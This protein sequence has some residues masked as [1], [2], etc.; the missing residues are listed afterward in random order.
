MAALTVFAWAGLIAGAVAAPATAERLIEIRVHGN[1]RVADVDIITWAAVYVGE[2]VGPDLVSAVERRLQE[3]GQFETVDVRKRYRSLTAGDEIALII[4][5]TER[6]VPA[7]ANP[8]ARLLGAF[9]RQ[10]L[11]LPILDYAEGYGFSYGVRTSFV[12]LLG[13][14]SRLSVPATWGGTKR[15]SLEADKELPGGFLTRVQGGVRA[16]RREH[17]R[18]GVDDDRAEVWVRAGRRLPGRLRAV[19]EAG[20]AD[21]RFGSTDDSVVRY[22]VSLEVDTRSDRV[23]PRDAVW[24]RASYEWL[25]LGE[26]RRVIG[27]PR[28]EVDA[29]AGLAGQVV[30][31]VRAAYAGADRSV[32]LYEQSLLGGG[33]SLRGWR[34]GAFAGDRR[35]NGS[36]EVRLPLT[37]PLAVGRTGAA[38]FYDIGA[39]FDLGQSI[40]DTR[41][42]HG[43]GAGLFV[44]AALMQLR[45]DVAH[46]LMGSVRLHFAAGVSF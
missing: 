2:Q 19:G 46:N 26:T 34:V 31:A 12:D 37:S 38:L 6:R 32:P 22:Q 9:G 8:G 10:A 25:D 39:A 3:T 14:S 5:V 35:A 4:V 40:R 17:P 44:D 45:L 11:L 33:S 43:A 20:W 29:F 21:V 42:R 16:V 27:R 13:A 30:L 7:S 41:F 1:Q 18:F 24:V 23:S 28:Y 15:V 36:V